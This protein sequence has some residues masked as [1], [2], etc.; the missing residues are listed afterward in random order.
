MEIVP[1][2]D[3]ETPVFDE[4]KPE[5]IHVGN[6]VRDALCVMLGIDTD[7]TDKELLEKAKEF[8]NE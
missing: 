8:A 6:P 7:S 5:I 1:I 2:L 3:T 4:G